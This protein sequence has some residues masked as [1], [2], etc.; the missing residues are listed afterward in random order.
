MQSVGS[1]NI[2]AALANLIETQSAGGSNAAGLNAL[3]GAG[4]NDATSFKNILLDSI[5]E[6]NAMQQDASAAVENLATGEDVNPA[7]VLTAV[8]KA[9]I[10]FRM[11]MQIRNK[12]VAAYSQIENIR[13]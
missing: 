7:E 6:V 10:A 13:V 12:L 9:D 8:Q 1:I 5:Q 4:G 2:N 3:G 11:M